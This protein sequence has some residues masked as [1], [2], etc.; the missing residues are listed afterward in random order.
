MYNICSSCTHNASIVSGICQCDIT[1]YSEL[2]TPGIA[3]CKSCISTC[4]DYCTGSTPCECDNISYPT[5]YNVDLCCYSSCP[6]G[7]QNNS[8]NCIQVNQTVLD[9]TF[10][11]FSNVTDLYGNTLSKSNT[12]ASPYRGDYYS[13]GAYSVTTSITLLY[14]FSLYI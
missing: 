14:T 4:L 2:Q 1:F 3:L 9:M 6:S 12:I 10:D 8:N 11:T 5:K 13:E 7:F